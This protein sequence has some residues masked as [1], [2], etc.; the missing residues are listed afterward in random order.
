MCRRG[1]GDPSYEMHVNTVGHE[2][3]ANQCRV[4]LLDLAKVVCMHGMIPG[5]IPVAGIT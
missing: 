3:T 4:R 5:I 2:N 1:V